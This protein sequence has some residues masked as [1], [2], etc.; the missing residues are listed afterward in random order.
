MYALEIQKGT[1]MLPKKGILVKNLDPTTDVF[2]NTVRQLVERYVRTSAQSVDAV[3]GYDE[4]IEMYEMTSHLYRTEFPEL[5]R[6]Y[7]PLYNSVWRQDLDIRLVKDNLHQ[8]ETIYHFAHGG[9]QSR[10]VNVWICLQKQFPAAFQPEELGIFIVQT[11]VPQND[12]IYSKLAA[13]NTHFNLIRPG[14]L[15]DNSRVG[16]PVVHLDTRKLARTQFPYF[17]GTAIA[18]NSHLLHG[19]QGV[20]TEFGKHEQGFRTTLASVWVHECDFAKEILEMSVDGFG[21][22]YLK[23][24]DQK[25]RDQMSTYFS[26]QCRQ[27]ERAISAIVA[28]AGHH[29]KVSRAAN[30]ALGVDTD[31]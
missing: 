12:D 17:A 21:D 8:D 4:F 14:Q 10:I 22:L 7:I 30:L 1:G 26:D 18:F 24:H 28:L 13:E 29:L 19:T 15:V 16:G 27:H 11:G 9:Y 5:W 3:T 23:G 25:T 2:Q 20:R 31:C 6:H